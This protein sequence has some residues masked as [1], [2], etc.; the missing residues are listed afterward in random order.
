M[1]EKQRQHPIRLSELAFACYVYEALTRYGDSYR[2]FLCATKGSP[3]LRLAAHRK[4][5]LKWLN[6]WGCR[7]AVAYHKDASKEILSWYGEYG[8]SLCPKDREILDLSEPELVA[9]GEA[10]EALSQR[11]ASYK[12]RGE[13][14]LPVSI[15]PAGASKVLFAIRP[16]AL[17]PWDAGIR[18]G[19][20]HSASGA[21][22][23][24]YLRG[25]RALLEELTVRCQRHRLELSRL[26]Q[27]LGQPDSSVAMLLNKYYWVTWTK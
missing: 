8:D 20:G 7:F 11:T 21:S 22:Y 15:G 2:R 4:A 24:C 25:A 13:E 10:Y 17:L 23:V 1:D 26:P 14:A 9:V 12:K 5:L 3:D 16:Q 18:K 27:E 19:L 6:A